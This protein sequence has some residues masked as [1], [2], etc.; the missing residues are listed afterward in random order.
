MKK[1]ILLIVSAI[2]VNVSMAQLSFGIQA[3][4]NI[5]FGKI[6][7]DDTGLPTL[8][9]NDPKIGIT[10][11][12]L[13]EIPIS[14]KL[15]FRPEIN[16]IQKGSKTNTTLSIFNEFHKITLNYIEIPLNVVYKMRAGRGNFFFG[17]GPTLSIGISGKEKI[18]NDYDPTK[19]TIV[20]VKFDGKNSDNLASNDESRHLKRFDAGANIL[21]GYKLPMG[22]FIKL[23]Y[24]YNFLNIDPNKNNGYKNRGFNIC[25]GYMLFDSKAKA[26]S[27]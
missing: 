2:T 22:L 10:G 11:G 7:V 13:A 17:L 6:T 4:A 20:D 5:A 16:F 21:A 14:E 15:A 25:V 3:G 9:T 19:D 8:F 27:D 18:T 1:I 23:G 12:F 26:P 24:T